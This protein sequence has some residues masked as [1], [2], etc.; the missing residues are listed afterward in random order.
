MTFVF[1]QMRKRTSKKSAGTSRKSNPGRQRIEADIRAVL[2]ANDPYNN[3]LPVHARAR[4]LGPREPS[5]EGFFPAREPSRF[6][7]QNS[8]LNRDLE[9][10]HL[11]RLAEL[12]RNRY[13]DE[14]ESKRRRLEH[15]LLTAQERVNMEREL[16]ELTV[17]A[18]E[19]ELELTKQELWNKHEAEVGSR[20][21]E[22]EKTRIKHE[23]EKARHEEIM[24][25][26][27]I[28]QT[29]WDARRKGYHLGMLDKYK[30]DRKNMSE[31]YDLA[32][33]G[34]IE[35][36]AARTVSREFMEMN[37]LQKEVEKKEREMLRQKQ[38]H[39]NESFN[40]DH[41]NAYLKADLEALK[42]DRARIEAQDGPRV[43]PTPRWNSPVPE[44]M[45]PSNPVGAPGAGAA[46]ILTDEGAPLSAFGLAPRPNIK[47]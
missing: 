24:R 46:G 36:E 34:K 7:P 29:L 5:Q 31:L 44:P 35:R 3:N 42:R 33:D 16:K 45:I 28:D 43:F 10:A 17:R 22:R 47:I 32:R 40:R 11:Q 27:D 21:L 19:A 38:L 12:N 8:G 18:Q 39:I 30:T 26:F 41:E 37:D 13:A 1:D 20:R 6:A 15:D 23:L 14:L 4:G 25:Q 2:R 9:A